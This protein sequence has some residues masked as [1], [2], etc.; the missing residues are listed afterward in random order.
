MIALRATLVKRDQQEN[1][2]ERSI[3]RALQSN[4]IDSL[5]LLWIRELREFF[6]KAILPENLARYIP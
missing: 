3:P 4:F 2:G 5:G 6:Q 1:F